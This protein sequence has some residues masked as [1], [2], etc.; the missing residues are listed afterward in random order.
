M[1]SDERARV[2]ALAKRLALGEALAL[3]RIV[4]VGFDEVQSATAAGRLEELRD[5]AL[6]AVKGN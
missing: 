6:V 1:S 3:E 5:Q 2:S 4:R